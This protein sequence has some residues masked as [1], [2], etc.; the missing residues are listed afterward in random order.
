[1]VSLYNVQETHTTAREH[2]I[3]DNGYLVI[4]S[5]SDGEKHA[6]VGFIVSPLLR[7]A[8]HSFDC[9]NARMAAIKIRISGGKIAFVSAYAPQVQGSEDVG[10]E[11]SQIFGPAIDFIP[12]RN[13]KGLYRPKSPETTNFD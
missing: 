11:G 2:F 3:R 1:M 8:V 5:G 9:L 12:P 6:G 7:K 13:S 10:G 4:L